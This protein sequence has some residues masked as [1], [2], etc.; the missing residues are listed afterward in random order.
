MAIVNGLAYDDSASRLLAADA[1]AGRTTIN[2]GHT[3]GLHDSNNPRRW[4]S[5]AD[6]RR[7]AT[8]IT[9]ALI[10]VEPGQAAYLCAPA[11]RGSTPWTS[12]PTTG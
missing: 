6:V 3:L 12:A 2:V 5:P 1:P 8:V 10:A 4:Y 11:P 7:I 9:A